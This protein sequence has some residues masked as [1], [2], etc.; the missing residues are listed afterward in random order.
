MVI[1]KAEDDE[2]EK[3]LEIYDHAR[4]FMRDN[5][6][7]DQ[8]SNTYPPKNQLEKSIQVG[9]LY[10][11]VDQD[12]LVGVFYFAEEEDPTYAV[13]EEG[14]WLNDNPYGVVHKIASAAGTKG[15]AT[16]CLNWAFEQT[17]NI[18][19][20]THELNVPMRAL[21]NKLGYKYCGRIYVADGSPRMAFQK[22]R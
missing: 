9:K 15:I 6:N 1:K 7:P 21:L 16:F 8:W 14:A 10:V 19:I 12:E 18:R 4:R 13:I 22:S 17:K 20:D 11:C 3:I 2:L 5:G